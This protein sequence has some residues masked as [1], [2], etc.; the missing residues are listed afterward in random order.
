MH[1]AVIDNR[2]SRQSPPSDKFELHR[3][4][5][6]FVIFMTFTCYA[7]SILYIHVHAQTHWLVFHIYTPTHTH[8]HVHIIPI[9][10]QVAVDQSLTVLSDDAVASTSP[11]GLTAM[12]L[13]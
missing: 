2:W 7:Y 13:I 8:T 3:N 5:T 10:V 1:A 9:S 12:E 11:D 4:D 6:M